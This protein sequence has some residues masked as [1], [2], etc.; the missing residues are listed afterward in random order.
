[1]STV[2]KYFETV[3]GYS[4]PVEPASEISE[5]ETRD[6]RAYYRVVFDELSRIMQVTKMLDSEFEVQFDYQS[7]A[8][9]QISGAQITGPD[10]RIEEIELP[11]SQRSRA[12]IRA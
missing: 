7:D 8:T 4:I 11:Q 5:A 6:R 2:T 9:G 1:M 3:L 10:R 12:R